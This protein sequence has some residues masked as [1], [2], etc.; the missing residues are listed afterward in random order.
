MSLASLC[1]TSTVFLMETCPLNFE[2]RDKVEAFHRSL[3]PCIKNSK[4]R[5]YTKKNLDL[6][7][8]CRDQ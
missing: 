3:N 1:S 4:I 6:A 8:I 5:E 2:R 7:F